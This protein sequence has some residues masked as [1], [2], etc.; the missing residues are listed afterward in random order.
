MKT[1]AT[2]AAAIAVAVATPCV[3][4]DLAPDESSTAIMAAASAVA[5]ARD[6][7]APVLG[8]RDLKPGGYWWNSAG[9]SSGPVEVRVSLEEQRA[10][11]YR[12]GELMGVST[13]SSGKPGK[14]TPPGIFPILE[15]KTMHRSRK[16]D[17]AP[18]PFMQ[19]ID[20]YGIALHAGHIPGRPASHGCVRLPSAFA[21]KL[22]GITKVGDRVVIG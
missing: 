3:A 9:P 7:A 1:F 11:V 13:I 20:N 17:N 14:D 16:Y 12:A 5:A 10:Y 18:M 2:L 15:K 4:A 22:F 6:E 8:D 21:A 19:R